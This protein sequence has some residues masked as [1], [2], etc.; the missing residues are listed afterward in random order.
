MAA[1]LL[2][3]HQLAKSEILTDGSLKIKRVWYRKFCRL[4]RLNPE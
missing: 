3:A 1:A 2:R 4:H